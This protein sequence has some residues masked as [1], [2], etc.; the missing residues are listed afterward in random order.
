MT[1]YGDHLSLDEVKRLVQ[2]LFNEVIKDDNNALNTVELKNKYRNDF[3]ELESRYPALYTMVIESKK[4]FDWNEFNFMMNMLN[5]VRNNQVSEND[6]SIYY[7]Q[8]M[9]D[10]YVKPKLEK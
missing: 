7:G 2:N 1:E 6:A 4:N 10:K 9:V 8:R 5:K 3:F